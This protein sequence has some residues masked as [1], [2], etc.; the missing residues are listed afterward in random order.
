MAK[1]IERLGYPILLAL[2]EQIDLVM[3]RLL[4]P[5][6]AEGVPVCLQRT[7]HTKAILALPLQPVEEG[8]QNID[9]DAFEGGHG[10]LLGEMAVSGSIDEIRIGLLGR[11]RGGALTGTKSF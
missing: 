3:A 2:D 4:L 6:E 9:R 10:V 11:T 5:Q 8:V 1:S 7:G